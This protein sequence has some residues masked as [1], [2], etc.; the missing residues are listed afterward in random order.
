LT[1]FQHSSRVKG[2]DDIDQ[3]TDIYLNTKFCILVGCVF[4]SRLAHIAEDECCFCTV[5]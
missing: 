1:R 4:W 5:L 3:E 2:V